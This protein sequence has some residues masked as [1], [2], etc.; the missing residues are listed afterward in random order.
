L[1]LHLQEKIKRLT[2]AI[3]LFIGVNALFNAMFNVGKN[4]AGAAPVLM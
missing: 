2:L 4:H 1:S 3:I